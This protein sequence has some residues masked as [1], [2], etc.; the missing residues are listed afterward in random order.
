MAAMYGSSP[1][2]FDGI[3]RANVEQTIAGIA[4]F[5]E[6]TARAG[7]D[8]ELQNH[9]LFDDM[10]SKVAALDARAQNGGR[11]PFVVGRDGYRNF[12]TVMSECFKAE[13][14]RRE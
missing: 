14:A 5:A 6:A 10:W 8:V 3:P 2:S 11:H 12:M 9:P 7:V 13:L 4:H 1:L